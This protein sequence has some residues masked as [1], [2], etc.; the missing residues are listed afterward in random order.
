YRLDWRHQHHQQSALWLRCND[1]LQPVVSKLHMSPV[2]LVLTDRSTCGSIAFGPLGSYIVLSRALVLMLDDEELE[3]LL[4]HELG[5]IKRKDTLFGVVVG[6]SRRLLAFSPFAQTACRSFSHAQE[7]ATD[8]LAIRTSGRPLALASCLV[9]A[10][11]LTQG[12]YD[13]EP[14]TCLL[15]STSSAEHRIRRLFENYTCVAE[16][17]GKYRWLFFG[18]VA[19]VFTILLLVV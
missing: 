3:G 10:C 5:H 11:R 4:A 7:E 14:S 15:S 13:R 1:M 9:K 18:L 16:P 8:D 2:R 17:S 6:A 12:H 19:V